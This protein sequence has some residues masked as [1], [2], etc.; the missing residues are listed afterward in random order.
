MPCLPEAIRKGADWQAIRADWAQLSAD[1][2]K[3][4]LSANI[5]AHTRL[6][7]RMLTFVTEVSDRYR[8]TQDPEVGSFY[9]METSLAKLPGLLE[10]L[11]RM[12][13]SG[14]GVLAAGALAPAQATNLN[15]AL[16]SIADLRGQY[17]R[18]LAKT[19]RENPAV[20]ATLDASAKKFTTDLEALVGVVRE[21]V[22]G[23]KFATPAATFFSQATATID[24]GY[25][26]IFETLIPTL[27]LLINQRIER[28]R[29]QMMMTLLGSA[30]C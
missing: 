23:Q 12:R 24:T 14:T 26:Q 29:S 6:I 5:A 17:E 1:G 30:P 18:N 25:S 9:L 11:G 3:L 21:D 28:L 20:A 27:E 8:L 15:I 19:T 4:E 22:L 10:T 13:A 16:A 2:L 7:G